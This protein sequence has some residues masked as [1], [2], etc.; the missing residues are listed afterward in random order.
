MAHGTLAEMQ[1]Q[2]QWLSSQPHS[3]KIVI[4]ENHDI[5]LDESCDTKFLTRSGDIVA[6]R[7]ELD[8]NG[9]QYL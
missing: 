5:L 9:I 7:K 6:E 1:A 4:A 8:W 2:L 3:H